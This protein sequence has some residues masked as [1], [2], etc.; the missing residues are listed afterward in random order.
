MMEHNIVFG[1]VICLFFFTQ[2][3]VFCVILIRLYFRKIRTYTAQ[4]YQKDLDFQKTLT[5]TIIETQEQVLTNISQD[6][7]DDAGQQ[8]TYL[9]FQLEN[10]KLDAPELTPSLEPISKA[11][12]E[13]SESIRGISHSLN[14]QLIS[15]QDLFITIEKEIERLNRQKSISFTYT[16]HGHPD[17]P[18]PPGH[19]IVI[20][21]IFQES[22]QNILK[23]ARA[24]KVAVDIHTTPFRLTVRDNG[25][26][27]DRN[28]IQTGGTLG[29]QNL[30]SRA[31]LIGYGVKIDTTPGEGTVVTLTA[32][33][34]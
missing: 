29:L 26:G 9:N 28:L 12:S 24:T 32:T 30:R 15:S 6:L 14:Y 33:P 16:T 11:V 10:L 20:Y 21:R 31:A 25:Q 27:F 5:T 19:Q 1:I 8:L 7:H 13:L 22:I 4:L 17:L 3:I 34:T 23:H 18:L 2:I